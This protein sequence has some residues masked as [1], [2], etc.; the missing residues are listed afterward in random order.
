M[1]GFRLTIHS[2]LKRPESGRGP[3]EFT[4]RLIDKRD[5]LTAA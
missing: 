1:D 3:S 4:C 5:H 2:T